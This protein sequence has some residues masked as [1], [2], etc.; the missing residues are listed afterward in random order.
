MLSE[1]QLLEVC[2][3]LSDPNRL[4]LYTLLLGS[5]RTNSELMGETRLSQNLLSHHLTVLTDAGLI[6]THR[7]VG[8]AR[9]HYYS[10]NLHMPHQINGWWRFH[11]PLLKPP[12]PALAWPRRVLF[13][14]MHNAARSLI[15]EA[16]ARHYASGALIPY[17]AGVMGDRHELPPLMVQVLSEHGVSVEGL[18][19]KGY[20][21]LIDVPF[22]YLVTVCDVVHETSIPQ[23]FARLERVHWSL[24]DPET[25]A[26]DEAGQLAAMRQL[27]GEIEE[28]LSLLVGRL[29]AREAMA[30][31]TAAR[32]ADV[33]RP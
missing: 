29:A 32:E 13:L 27:Y 18:S 14:C 23:E 1:E 5:D 31:E 9:R 30:R 10:P 6:E 16:L 11:V 28:R 22:D 25:E 2:K 19:M 21:M 26:R 12:F 3:A 33:E 17:S 8:D 24:P 15:C 7:S 20:D 4:K